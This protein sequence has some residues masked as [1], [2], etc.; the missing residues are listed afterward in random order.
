[1]V[2]FLLEEFFEEEK[3]IVTKNLTAEIIAKIG[4]YGASTIKKSIDNPEKILKKLR[5][6]YKFK[7]LIEELQIDIEKNKNLDDLFSQI[8]LRINPFIYQNLTIFESIYAKIIQNKELSKE[9]AIFLIKN[10]IITLQEAKN[11][12]NFQNQNLII[13]KQFHFLY[14]NIFP[15]QIEDIRQISK[16]IKKNLQKNNYHILKSFFEYEKFYTLSVTKKNLRKIIKRDQKPKIS[17][18][19]KIIIFE[20]ELT[21]EEKDFKVLNLYFIYAYFDFLEYLRKKLRINNY[22]IKIFFSRVD[23]L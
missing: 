3:Q 6:S 19:S 9:E 2:P 18:F 16:L 4:G 22:Q 10:S 17:T 20:K 12:T 15:V 11:I 1:M 14:K 7:N 5:N 8:M 13:L 23:I 21:K